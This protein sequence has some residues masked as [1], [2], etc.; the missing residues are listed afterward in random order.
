ML[1]NQSTNKQQSLI[2]PVGP[3]SVEYCW[4]RLQA[5]SQLLSQCGSSI[6]NCLIR[7]VPDI[8]RHVAGTLNYQQTPVRYSVFIKPAYGSRRED[9][10]LN[11]S[12]PLFLNVVAP[13]ILFTLFIARYARAH[14]HTHTHTYT[15]TH[16][17]IHTQ[18]HTT[19]MRSTHNMHSRRCSRARAHTHTHTRIHKRSHK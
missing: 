18:T 10:A 16:T 14:T 12:I 17:H 3:V 5:C 1:S 19:P 15:Y 11:Q 6:Y 7:S 4:V 8:H 2:E 9:L 13:W